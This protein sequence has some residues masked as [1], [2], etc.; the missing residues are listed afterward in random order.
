MI[1]LHNIL[2]KNMIKLWYMRR[3]VCKTSKQPN[4]QQEDMQN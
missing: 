1:Y 3:Y 4:Q 2:I